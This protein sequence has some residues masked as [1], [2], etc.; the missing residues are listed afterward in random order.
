MSVSAND[1]ADRCRRSCGGDEVRRS[2]ARVFSW[3]LAL[4]GD[5]EEI[6]ENWIVNLISIS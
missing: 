1:G 3:D 6:I 5:E 4:E 2:A